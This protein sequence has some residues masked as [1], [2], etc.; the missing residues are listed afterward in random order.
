M[1]QRRGDVSGAAP[2]YPNQ[3]RCLRQLRGFRQEEGASLLGPL[4]VEYYKDIEAGRRFPQERILF[5]LLALYRVS[6]P[7]AYP[8]LAWQA[9]ATLSTRRAARSVPPPLTR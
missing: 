9:E 2:R 1:S 6:L 3:W 8:D 4:N 7:Q 5:L